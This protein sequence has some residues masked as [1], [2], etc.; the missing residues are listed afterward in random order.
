MGFV[1]KELRIRTQGSRGGTHE[2]L[3]CLVLEGVAAAAAAMGVPGGGG[4]NLWLLIW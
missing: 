2:P 1:P 4:W 3:A